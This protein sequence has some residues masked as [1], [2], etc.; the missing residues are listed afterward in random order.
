[1]PELRQNI[2]D[3]LTSVTTESWRTF[4]IMSEMVQA[5]DT[6]NALNVN[7]ISIFGSARAA[8]DSIQYQDAEKIA[9]LLAGAGFGV[10]TGGGPGIM[11]AA[12]KGACEAGGESVGLHIHLQHEQNCNNYVKTRCDFR[13]FFI[14][15]F[16][17]LKYAMAYIVMPG[18][19]GTI[20][21]FSDAF[22]PAQTGRTRPIPIILYDSSFWSGL[23]EWMRTSMKDVGFIRETEISKLVTVCDTPEDVISHLRKI[24]SCRQTETSLHVSSDCI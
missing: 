16:M 3:D 24:I 11:E 10:I 6:L 20:D 19:M 4:R 7:C 15:K 5:L 21:E 1:M 23:L 8:P 2:V 14:R 13:Y 18:G 17:F 9:R 12:N 22:V